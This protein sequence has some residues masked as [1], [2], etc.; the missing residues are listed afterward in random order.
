MTTD[1]ISRRV[2]HLVAVEIDPRMADVLEARLS[3]SNVEVVRADA[4]QLSY[5]DN[6][7]SGA[8]SFTML[9]HLPSADLQDRLLAEVYRVLRPGGIFAGSDSRTGPLFRVA[10]L[11]DTMV[12][13]DPEKF[14]TRLE[15]AEFE[16]V[17]VLM[18]EKAF[19]FQGRI[20]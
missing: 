19:K 14:G 4:T 8:V 12:L 3:G 20:A 15:K 6:S 17:S 7:F 18:A 5:G 9:H 13:V 2:A 16:Q 11:F 1:V 10:H